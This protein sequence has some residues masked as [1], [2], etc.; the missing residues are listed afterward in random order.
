M[1]RKTCLKLPIYIV[2][3]GMSQK[4]ND[5]ELHMSESKK[6]SIQK[7][8]WKVLI[9]LQ[10]NAYPYVGSFNLGVIHLKMLSFVYP[11]VKN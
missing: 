7:N 1:L 3:I 8:Y 2:I 6:M 9:F 5:E 11:N 4:I 10:I